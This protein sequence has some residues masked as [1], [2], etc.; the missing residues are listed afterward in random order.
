MNLLEKKFYYPPFPNKN[1]NKF[2]RNFSNSHILEKEK[3]KDINLSKEIFKHTNFTNKDEKETIKICAHPNS[4]KNYMYNNTFYFDLKNWK[5]FNKPTHI[6][7][8]VQML[9]SSKT[10]KEPIFKDKK[11]SKNLK[12]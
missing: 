10:I 11:E 9:S 12:N 8:K 2:L 3:E 5:E 6:T 7:T 1:L 4:I